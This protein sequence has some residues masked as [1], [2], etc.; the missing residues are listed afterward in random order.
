SQLSAGCNKKIM[1]L[2]DTIV[3]EPKDVFYVLGY[4]EKREKRDAV[5][6][7]FEQQAIVDIMKDGKI[8]LYELME[9]SGMNIAVVSSILTKLEIM[10][11]IRK[12]QGNYY[13]IIPTI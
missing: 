3:L 7:D 12:S 5:Q 8:H 10:G 1:D 11:V 6:L 4:E 9:K 13:E 2:Q